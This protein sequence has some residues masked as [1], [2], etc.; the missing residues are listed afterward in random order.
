MTLL[1]RHIDFVHALRRAGLTV[2]LAEALDAVQAIGV[3]GIADRERLRASYAAT[4][5]KRKRHRES[6][7]EIF[8]LYFPARVG[9]GAQSADTAVGRT[10]EPADTAVGRLPDGPAELAAFQDQL[11]TALGMGDP[12]AME[13]LAREAVQRFG[14]IRGRGPGE[15]RWST[16]NVMNRTSPESLID[17][18]MK[19]LLGELDDDPS[20][21]RLVEAQVKSFERLVD[22]EV[23]RRAAEVRGP[24]YVA[25]HTVTRSI[26]QR[27]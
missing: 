7:D 20:I 9:D 21:R 2:S 10:P 4:I 24:E 1:D 14:L 6:F 22:A 26:E 12:E 23:R 25:R 5:V 11:V 27:D 3:V 18:T 13:A 19:G 17:R 16:Y 15:Q 8:D